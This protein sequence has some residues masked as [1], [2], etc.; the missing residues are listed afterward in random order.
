MEAKIKIVKDSGHEPGDGYNMYM[1]T[2][3]TSWC[4]IGWLFVDYVQ[5]MLDENHW[6]ELNN[7]DVVELT[8][9]DKI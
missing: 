1:W 7:N 3:G 6:S 2:Y 9:K 8:I 5:E 4:W